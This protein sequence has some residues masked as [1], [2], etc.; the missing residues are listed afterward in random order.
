MWALFATFYVFDY[1]LI[2]DCFCIRHIYIS[3]VI[4]LAPILYFFILNSNW[5]CMKFQLLIKLKYWNIMTFQSCLAFKLSVMQINVKKPTMIGIL[6]F[7]GMIHFMHSW[8]EHEQSFITS[9]HCF[10]IAANYSTPKIYRLL[11]IL[12]FCWIKANSILT[13]K[14]INKTKLYSLWF[15]AQSHSDCE[16]LVKPLILFLLVVQNGIK[17]SGYFGCT[18]WNKP[19][20]GVKWNKEQFYSDRLW[21]SLIGDQRRKPAIKKMPTKMPLRLRKRKEEIFCMEREVRCNTAD[22]QWTQK[23]NP[24]GFCYLLRRLMRVCRFRAV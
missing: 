18:K 4:N 22:Q 12:V 3:P 16:K 1:L 7:L 11:F 5:L 19:R 10:S 2:S 20:I 17:F 6:T 8:V 14:W 23:T 15:K 21:Q 24:M 13:I 9:E